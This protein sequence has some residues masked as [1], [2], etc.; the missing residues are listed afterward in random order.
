MYTCPT[1]QP[2]S[3]QM[4]S[5]VARSGVSRSEAWFAAWVTVR[6]RSRYISASA[7][8]SACM[9]SGDEC[10]SNTRPSC[11][12]ICSATPKNSSSGSRAS[13]VKNSRTA[14]TVLRTRTGKPKPA[15]TPTS[16]AR[17][18]RGKFGLFVTSGIQ[19]GLPTTMTWPGS[20]MP[21][22]IGVFMVMSRKVRNRSGSSRR[23]MSAGSRWYGGSAERM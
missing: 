17:R 3:R 20:P 6:S 22:G 11:V 18:A 8:V 16:E 10:R 14:G 5:S 2:V 19:A 13:V 1:G 7:R 9:W 4:A 23:Q 21:G 15:R 12:P